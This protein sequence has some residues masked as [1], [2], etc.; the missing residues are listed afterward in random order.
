VADTHYL[1][2][3][4]AGANSTGLRWICFRQLYSSNE[5]PPTATLAAF[6]TL[7][8]GFAGR[9]IGFTGTIR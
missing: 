7:F 4:H 9:P 1:F 2:D 3:D 8:I 5:V 6:G